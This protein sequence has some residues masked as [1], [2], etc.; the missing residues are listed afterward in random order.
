VSV[1]GLRR[2]P[3]A[4]EGFAPPV[5]VVLDGPEAGRPLAVADVSLRGFR[6]AVAARSAG[7]RDRRRGAAG[8]LQE[9]PSVEVVA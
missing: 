6:G 9:G 5:G 8:E 4:F 3:V 1:V 2:H 7:E